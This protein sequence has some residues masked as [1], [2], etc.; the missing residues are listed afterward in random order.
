MFGNI[1]S[2]ILKGSFYLALVSQVNS[3]K[4][5][6]LS[7]V[8]A[9]QHLIRWPCD[10]SVRWGNTQF[11]SISTHHQLSPFQPDLDIFATIAQCPYT[12]I[13]PSPSLSFALIRKLSYAVIDA[14]KRRIGLNPLY[15]P[16]VAERGQLGALAVDGA[17]HGLQRLAPIARLEI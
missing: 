2:L 15:I 12:G 17:K 1:P 7:G 9:W 11:Q 3:R 6:S 8:V 5:L 16:A 14:L 13:S 10:Y 4:E